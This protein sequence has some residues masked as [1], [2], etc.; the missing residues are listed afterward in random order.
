MIINITKKGLII[1]L[2]SFVMIS[3]STKDEKILVFSKT[4]GFRHGSIESGIS[5]IKKLGKEK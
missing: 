3:C 2:I 4:A 1:L 5:A